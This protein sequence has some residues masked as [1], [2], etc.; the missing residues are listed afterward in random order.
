M[1]DQKRNLNPIPPARVAM[2]IWGEE[3][4][5]TSLGSMDFWDSLGLNRKRRCILVTE[6]LIK[7]QDPYLTFKKFQIINDLR[8]NEWHGENEDQSLA[9]FGNALA[10]EAGELCNFLK[11][12]R[13]V[14][15]GMRYRASEGNIIELTERASY[16]IADVIIQAFLVAT[17]LNLDVETILKTKFNITSDEFGFSQKL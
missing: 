12:I 17:E 9:D 11:K 1:N 2:I 4:A 14:Q 6:T 13:R 15:S 7:I 3:Y 16:E 10:G 8:S 5:N